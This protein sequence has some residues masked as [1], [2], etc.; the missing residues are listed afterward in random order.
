MKNEKTAVF[1]LGGW[2]TK[3]QDGVWRTLEGALGDNFGATNDRWRVIAAKLLYQANPDFFLIP[4]GGR[5]QLKGIMPEGLTI[6]RVIKDELV[7]LGVPERA[8]WEEDKTGTTYRQLKVLIDLVKEKKLGRV[9]ILSNRWHTP[10]VRAMIDHAPGL[11]ALRSMSIEVISAEDIM[12][13][14]E[15]EKWQ[16][17]INDFYSD[18][19]LTKR[20]ESEQKGISQIKA[21]TY[22]YK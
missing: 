2:L 1:I 8:I 4:S 11:E 10:R 6:A 21:G 16:K 15:P 5:G 22:N 3:G 19:D 20:M 7:A 17:K 13:K 12:L 14:Y 9:L 18:P